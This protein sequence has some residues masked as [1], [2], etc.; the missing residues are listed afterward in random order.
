MIGSGL[1]KK[2]KN[3]MSEEEIERE[4]YARVEFKMN[5]LLTGV[6]NRL[7]VKYAQAWDMTHDSQ[8][9]WQAFE[10]LV[11]LVKKEVNMGTPHDRMDIQARWEA[12]QVAVEKIMEKFDYRG[13]GREYDSVLKH[14]VDEV[15]RAQNYFLPKFLS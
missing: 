1:K 15:E 4:V 5:E 3:N 2:I 6:K 7:K 9:K 13:R 12:K 10:E 8:Y 11:A 14:V